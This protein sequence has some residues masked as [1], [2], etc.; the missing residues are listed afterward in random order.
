MHLYLYLYL[1][2]IFTP[3]KTNKTMMTNRALLYHTVTICHIADNNPAA[4]AR[5]MPVRLT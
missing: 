1:Y 5:T 2:L 4:A 3:R